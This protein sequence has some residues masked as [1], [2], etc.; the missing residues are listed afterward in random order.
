MRSF[1]QLAHSAVLWPWSLCIASAC[2]SDGGLVVTVPSNAVGPPSTPG[3]NSPLAVP[4]CHH[5]PRQQHPL[6]G[7]A[8][9]QGPGPRGCLSTLGPLN[10][11]LP[12]FRTGRLTHNSTLP[13]HWK[14]HVHAHQVTTDVLALCVERPP[15][16]GVW[17]PGAQ[18]L[19]LCSILCIWIHSAAE[20]KNSPAI[21]CGDPSDHRLLWV[22]PG[23]PFGS[24]C[25]R[26]SQLL[27]PLQPKT[28]LHMQ[29]RASCQSHSANLPV[30]GQVQVSSNRT[31]E[32]RHS[33]EPLPTAQRGKAK[34]TDTVG[35]G[36]QPLPP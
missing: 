11:M 3:T 33:P 28:A 4:F 18:L 9:F 1:V 5:Q 34:D 29:Y 10:L 12:H 36:L 27:F 8:V 25:A 17:D 30:Q 7:E 23:S 22:Q 14:S 21:F 35:E 20:D 15:W 24:L 2:G 19:W 13:G 26:H 6:V 31:G 16:T 32:G